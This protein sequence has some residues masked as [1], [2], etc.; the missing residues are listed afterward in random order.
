MALDT[1]EVT[2]R[3]RIEHILK[4][5]SY[6]TD[7]YVKQQSIPGPDAHRP[8][9]FLFAHPEKKQQY[10]HVFGQIGQRNRFE[11]MTGSIA[12]FNVVLEAKAEKLGDVEKAAPQIQWYL[13]RTT[14][15]FGILTNGRCWRLCPRRGG[16]GCHYYEVDWIRLLKAIQVGEQDD[17]AFSFFYGIPWSKKPP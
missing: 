11:N 13:R 3:N 9:M 4:I 12:K 7:C 6:D 5:L 8:D 17:E 2:I 10:L 14:A 1:R 15:P 16:S